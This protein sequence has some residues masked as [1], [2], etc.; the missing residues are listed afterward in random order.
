MILTEDNMFSPV[1]IKRKSRNDLSM[2]VDIRLQTIA[3]A[4]GISKVFVVD[5]ITRVEESLPRH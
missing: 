5:P 4:L 2:I 1:T 3:L